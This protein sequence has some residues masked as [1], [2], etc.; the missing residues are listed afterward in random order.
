MLSLLLAAIFFV[1]GGFHIYWFLGGTWGLDYVI[2]SKTPTT[3]PLEIP[4][5][6]TLMV[7]LVLVTFGGLYLAKLGWITLPLP[8]TMTRYAYWV[9]PSIFILRAIGEFNY[10]GFFKKIKHTTFAQADS[11]LFSPLCLSIGI[12]GLLVQWLSV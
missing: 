3:L 8:H 2:P 10:I 12:M 1:L 6:A 9:I 7:A 4:R 5:I 11:K